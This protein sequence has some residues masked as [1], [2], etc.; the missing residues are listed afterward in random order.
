[1]RRERERVRD[2][3]PVRRDGVLLGGFRRRAAAGGPADRRH[4]RTY[5]VFG[6][7]KAQREQMLRLA[8]RK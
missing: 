5:L 6:S 3:E 4:L 1:M 8:M 7:A 2:D